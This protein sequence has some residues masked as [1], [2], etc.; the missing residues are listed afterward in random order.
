MFRFPET[1]LPLRLRDTWSE[2][3]LLPPLDTDYPF[4]VSASVSFRLLPTWC[5]TAV[6]ASIDVFDS[7]R[8]AARGAERFAAMIGPH[9]GHLV[10]KKSF[11]MFSQI[12]EC[13]ACLVTGRGERGPAFAA[14][15]IE[16]SVGKEAADLG[17]FSWTWSSGSYRQLL[18]FV[19]ESKSLKQAFLN[20]AKIARELYPYVLLI[21]LARVLQ[22]I[23]QVGSILTIE[24]A[25]DEVEVRMAA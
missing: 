13:L 17:L 4:A 2:V 23:E 22:Y 14:L 8:R 24:D 18:V 3:T 5:A 25:T 7:K 16:D 9:W 21:V 19:E 15:G 20:E 6:R 10:D 1:E 11:I 12:G